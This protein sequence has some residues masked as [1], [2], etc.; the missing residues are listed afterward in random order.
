[1][2]PDDRQLARGHPLGDGRRAGHAVGAGLDDVPRLELVDAGQAV[3][4][5]QQDRRRHPLDD[6]AHVA[7]GHRAVVERG[8]R[9]LDRAAAVVAEHTI[10]GTS[11]TPTAYSMEPNTA[12]SMTW[13]AVR[14]TNMSPRPW[15]KMSSA[16]TR[17][18]AQPN[19]TA[20]GFWPS[21]RLARCSM[22]WLG[23]LG[24]AGDESLVTLF[25]CLPR[26]YRTGVGHGAHCAAA[27]DDALRNAGELLDWYDRRDATCRGASPG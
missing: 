21:A 14:T 3:A 13:P 25:E 24:L 27:A 2:T 4:A 12:E 5:A 17:L 9:R 10:S 23:M 20:V 11:S 8:Q 7:A 6:V 22:L 18:S 1:M 16:A 26:G 19:T 15:S